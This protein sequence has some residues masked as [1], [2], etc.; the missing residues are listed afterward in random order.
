MASDVGME[1]GIRK[2][3]QGVDSLV[4]RMS[5]SEAPQRA[6]IDS[7]QFLRPLVSALE[8]LMFA[9]PINHVLGRVQE[10]KTVSCCLDNFFMS[11]RSDLLLSSKRQT[12]KHL[13]SRAWKAIPLL[14]LTCLLTDGEENPYTCCLIT[15]TSCSVLLILYSSIL[16]FSTVEPRVSTLFHRCYLS[17]RCVCVFELHM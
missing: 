4:S 2:I 15:L 5:G 3:S 16:L 7:Q 12:Q 6:E 13:C 17:L 1:R 10:V 9:D 11:A 14:R 8:K